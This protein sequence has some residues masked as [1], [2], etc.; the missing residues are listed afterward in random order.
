MSTRGCWTV[1]RKE[2][3]LTRAGK[4]IADRPTRNIVAVL[5][6]LYFSPRISV[7]FYKIKEERT[8]FLEV[9]V[10]AILREKFL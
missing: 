9:I 3:S 8:I 2:D 6:V 1:Q 5:T 10:L 4:Q 7:K